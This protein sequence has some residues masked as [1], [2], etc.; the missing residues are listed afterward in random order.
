MLWLC[1]KE[2]LDVIEFLLHCLYEIYYCFHLLLE[3]VEIALVTVK[4]VTILENM[5]ELPHHVRIN[6]ENFLVFVV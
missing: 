4:N 2:R 1:L 6:D 5:V 3:L